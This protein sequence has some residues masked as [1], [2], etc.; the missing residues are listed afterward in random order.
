MKYLLILFTIISSTAFSQKNDCVK[1][2]PEPT[3]GSTIH[4]KTTC[5]LDRA[6]NIL[7]MSFVKKDGALFLE[8]E[9]NSK[10]LNKKIILD[11]MIS[12]QFVFVDN[13]DYTIKMT[14]P[15]AKARSL[16]D[17]LY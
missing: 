13:S 15:E 3:D 10:G 11:S 12:I 4:S 7:N 2:L 6:P 14:Q 9:S 1:Y 8:I 5:F 16:E 17:H